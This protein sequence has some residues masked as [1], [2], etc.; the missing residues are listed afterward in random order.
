MSSKNHTNQRLGFSALGAGIVALTMMAPRPAVASLGG[1]VVS[2]QRDQASMKATLRS[3]PAARY[4][5]HEMETASGSKVREYATP[6]G[7]VFAV[8]WQGTFHP[9]YRQLLGD[10]F[11]HLTQSLQR[12]HARRAPVIINEPDFV[13]ETAGHMRSLSGRAYLPQLIPQGVSAKEIQ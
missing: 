1:D 11:A 6:G 4:T 9:G 8:A 2:V 10:H 13:F 5:V 7:K 3:T 12:I